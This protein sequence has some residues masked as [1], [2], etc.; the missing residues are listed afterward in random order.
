MEFNI[1]FFGYKAKEETKKK[2]TGEK[3]NRQK[4]AYALG[5]K[6]PMASLLIKGRRSLGGVA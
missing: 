6:V 2:E 1:F 4:E 3:Q 5:K